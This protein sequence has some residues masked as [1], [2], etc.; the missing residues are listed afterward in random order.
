MAE[1]TGSLQPTR[2]FATEPTPEPH[3][4]LGDATVNISEVFNALKGCT[5]IVPM[6]IVGGVT[7]RLT[8]PWEGEGPLNE[9]TF[10]TAAR[11]MSVLVRKRL[12]EAQKSE[13]G[14]GV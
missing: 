6:N 3:V 1:K 5:D 7:E 13:S 2:I 9:M 14:Q 10:A 11:V 4:D 8:K 12:L